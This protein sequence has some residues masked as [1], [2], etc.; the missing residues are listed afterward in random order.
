MARVD[1]EPTLT[2]K[3]PFDATFCRACA[4]RDRRPDDQPADDR[5]GAAV[6]NPI[7]PTRP[8]PN[9]GD[10]ARGAGTPPPGPFGQ[11]GTGNKQEA[12]QPPPGGGEPPLR[13]EALL[14]ATTAGTIGLV[15]A[16]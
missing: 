13:R 7:L 15:F 10:L 2:R 4:E 6:L 3:E 11:P 12:E 9:A 5:R 8:P 14:I 1:V 16:L